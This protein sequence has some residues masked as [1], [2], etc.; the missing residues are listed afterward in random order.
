MLRKI[1]WVAVK[2]R[3]RFLFGLILCFCAAQAWAK[4]SAVR[5]TGKPPVFEDFPVQVGSV[6]QKYASKVILAT[7]RS[8]RYRTVI[9]DGGKQ[10]PD[11]AGIYRVATWG[12]G[13]D[14]R[15]FAIINRVNGIVYTPS[16]FEL[17]AGVMGNSENRVQYRQDSRLMILTGILDDDE[18]REGKYFFEWTGKDLKLIFK[19]RVP[20]YEGVDA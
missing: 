20:K 9:S 7:P 10:A 13:T 16:S 11:F 15:G 3:L 17:L 14:C 8:R 18:K 2:H 1:T 4:D 12:C 19:G 5:T 6:P